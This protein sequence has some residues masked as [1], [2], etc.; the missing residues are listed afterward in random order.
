MGKKNRPSD[1][2]IKAGD[3]VEMKS[4][5]PIMT[6]ESVNKHGM[7]LCCHFVGNQLLRVGINTQSL[8]KVE[9]QAKES[10]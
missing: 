8:E 5:S 9:A 10:A 4:G 6:V 7:A 1:W 2:P 3:V